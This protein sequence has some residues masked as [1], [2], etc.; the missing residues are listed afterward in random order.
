MRGSG[1]RKNSTMSAFVE[2]SDELIG[3][4]EMSMSDDRDVAVYA[5]GI[6]R[7]G[8]ITGEVS[9][10]RLSEQILRLDKWSV[11]RG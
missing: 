11:C 2:I 9:W 7:D 10:S 1:R 3:A 8:V 5:L 4:V 6:V